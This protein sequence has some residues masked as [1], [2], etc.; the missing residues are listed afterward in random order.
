M[1]TPDTAK[2]ATALCS[3]RPSNIE[4][5]PG[6]LKKQLLSKPS[7]R[8]QEDFASDITRSELK[9]RYAT[10]R[11]LAISR[12]EVVRLVAEADRR[13]IGTGHGIRAWRAGAA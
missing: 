1:Q 5:L 12:S 8:H 9:G 11:D 3:E 10:N 4:Q 7:N 6:R 2:A 13:I